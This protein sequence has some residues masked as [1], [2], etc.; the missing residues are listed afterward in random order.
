MYPFSTM[1]TN[2]STYITVQSILSSVGKLSKDMGRHTLFS[3]VC[4]TGLTTAKP[5]ADTVTRN[6][7]ESLSLNLASGKYRQTYGTK[8]HNRM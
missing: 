3:T 4:G 1:C 6:K 8:K 7:V 5:G 2:T